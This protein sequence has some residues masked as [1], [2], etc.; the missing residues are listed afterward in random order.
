MRPTN[1]PLTVLALGVLAILASAPAHGQV[2]PTG[3]VSGRILGLKQGESVRGAKVV[4]VRFTLD[5]NGQPKGAPVQMKDADANG[6]YV[7]EN[8]PVDAHSVYQLGTRIDGNLIPS[9]SFTFPDDHR[10]ITLNL[11]VPEIVT[12]ST[13]VRIVQA[14]IAL[15]PQVG[16]VWVTD[17]VH[18]ENPTKDVIEGVQTPLELSV[19]SD[20]QNVEVIHQDQQQ[21]THQQVGDKLLIFGNLQPGVTTIAV[22]YRMPVQL[23]N[24][25]L[26]KIYPRPVAEMVVLAPAGLLKVSSDRLDA[27]QRQTIE[28]QSYDVW[29]GA[30]L[31]PQ[32][33][34]RI[35]AS[36]VPM[37]Q[38]W[39]LV[40][41]GLFLVIMA[42]VVFWYVR[43]RLPASSPQPA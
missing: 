39:L 17:V 28:G 22:R 6:S 20:A 42:A 40:P 26:A 37:Q 35:S 11:R 12:D 43:K 34:V 18:L 15:E 5:A 10:T 31:A 8:V 19:P 4:L 41:F 29:G 25:T 27:R 1:W 36:G 23:G 9:E 2:A 24:L 3:T 21:G 30:N 13:S 16:A 14:L 33:V 7:F 32:G 38:A